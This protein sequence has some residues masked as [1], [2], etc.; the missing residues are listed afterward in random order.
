[1]FV[2]TE[3]KKSKRKPQR[4]RTSKE[5][6]SKKKRKRKKKNQS[7]KDRGRAKEN[8]KE[9]KQS[10]GP[11]NVWTI[12]RIVKKKKRGRGAMVTWLRHGGVKWSPSLVTNQIFVSTLLFRNKPK[13]KR[14]Q[15]GERLEQP[16]PNFLPKS[17]LIKSYWSMMIKMKHLPVWDF[18]HLERFSSIRLDAVFLLILF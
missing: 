9:K 17:D 8:R 16:K 13:R 1:M 18:R 7:I 15:K 11:D 4:T 3:K 14:K 6:K 2:K 12:R 10:F 5:R